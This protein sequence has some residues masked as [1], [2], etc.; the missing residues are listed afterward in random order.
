M[1]KEENISLSE[2]SIY[3]D[4][5]MEYKLSSVVGVETSAYYFDPLSEKILEKIDDVITVKELIC[6]VGG[7]PVEVIKNLKMLKQIGLV[8][9]IIDEDEETQHVENRSSDNLGLLSDKNAMA[10]LVEASISSFS[11]SLSFIH[12]KDTVTFYFKKGRPKGVKATA[13]RH[14]HGTMLHGEGLIDDEMLKRY[15]LAIQRNHSPIAALRQA[16]VPDRVTMARFVIWRA[17]TLFTE[18]LR[19]SDGNYEITPYDKFP[20]EIVC[21]NLML[22]SVQGGAWAG[23]L[24]EEQEQFM[25]EKRTWF[26]CENEAA[27]SIIDNMGLDEAER[28]FVGY[29]QDV[30]PV[31]VSKAVTL[32]SFYR[33]KANKIVYF[34]IYFGAFDIQKDKPGGYAPIPLDELES[35][36]QKFI[37]RNHFEV[38]DA[39]AVSNEDELSVL[40]K[41]QIKKFDVKYFEKATSVHRNILNTIKKRINE[42]WKVLGD[43]KSRRQYRNGIYSP[44][45]LENFFFLQLEKAESALKM[46]SDYGEALNLAISAW[47]LKPNSE[48]ARSLI[49]ASLKKLGRTNEISKYYVN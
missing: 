5:Y 19:W 14:D 18:V 8:D 42:A 31:L 27:A 23:G 26:M 21:C 45:Q 6:E 9:W 34:L 28:R 25:L 32:A 22:K 46:R 24:S 29:I 17:K 4:D 49:T 13:K 30:V 2:E 1:E 44:Y 40:Y 36:Y 15:Q 35:Y 33:A 41:K 39:H 20:S 38:L 47:D 7:D 16:G 37:I 43:A 48:K 11:G 10:L 3:I 12:G